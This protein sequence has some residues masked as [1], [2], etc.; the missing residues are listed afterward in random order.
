M[1]YGKDTFGRC[2]C[3][4]SSFLFGQGDFSV[5]YKF[6]SS[7]NKK[8]WA[9]N[10]ILKCESNF[11]CLSGFNR[12]KYIYFNEHVR[13]GGKVVEYKVYPKQRSLA[14]NRRKR[15]SLDSH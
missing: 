15:I 12:L 6:V 9:Y 5:Y 1:K 2:T 7:D 14:E 4:L 13:F 10:T 11:G 8:F 3:R